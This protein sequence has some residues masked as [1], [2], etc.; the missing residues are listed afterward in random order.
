MPTARDLQA[1]IQA[2][3]DDENQRKSVSTASTGTGNATRR[4]TST[5][6][7]P[8]EANSNADSYYA[9]KPTATSAALTSQPPELMTGTEEEGSHLATC[10]VHGRSSIST[11]LPEDRLHDKLLSSRNHQGSAPDPP[12]SNPSNRRSSPRDT[13]SSAVAS[14]RTQTPDERLRD[15]IARASVAG[16][17]AEANTSTAG[18]RSIQGSPPTSKVDGAGDDCVGAFAVQGSSHSLS[19]HPS[20]QAAPGEALDLTE[21][22]ERW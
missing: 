22:E 10:N 16:E 3:I 19:R 14:T 15:K 9:E 12:V 4:S 17:A 11:S 1:K 18:A 2:K 21:D 8:Y 5:R 13:Q 6:H 7:S 20:T